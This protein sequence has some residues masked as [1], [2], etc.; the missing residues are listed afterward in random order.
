MLDKNILDK[1]LREYEID[2]FY[3][4]FTH[5]FTEEHTSYPYELAIERVNADV[6]DDFLNRASGKIIKF[7]APNWDCD[8]EDVMLA[9][10][11]ECLTV[12]GKYELSHKIFAKDNKKIPFT[13]IWT[14][15]DGFLLTEEDE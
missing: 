1:T 10:N 13:L 2:K 3:V 7:F 8:D 9:N 5:P 6:A 12:A 14:K 15:E 11:L 4:N